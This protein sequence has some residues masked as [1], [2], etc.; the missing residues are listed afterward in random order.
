MLNIEDLCKHAR[1]DILL[2]AVCLMPG[3][4][5]FACRCMR[6]FR[7]TAHRRSSGEIS[8]CSGGVCEESV[9]EPAH[10][11]RQAAAEAPRAPDGVLLR[12]RADFLRSTGG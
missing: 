2:N 12:H 9:P 5:H 11:L 4:I 6:S 1:D 8:V 10:T 3:Y 7:R